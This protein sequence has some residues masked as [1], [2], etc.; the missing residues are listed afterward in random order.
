M[1]ILR[2]MRLLPVVVALAV[3]SISLSPKP[4]QAADFTERFQLPEVLSPADEDRYRR[5]FLLQK[6]GA[7]HKA[8][9]IIAQLEDKLLLGHVMAQRYLHPRKYRSK[10]KEL[11]G[12]MAQYADHP[13]A[14]QIYKLAMRRRPKNWRRPAA[15][16][17][18]KKSVA[19]ESTAPVKSSLRVPGKRRS[20]AQ[21]RWV[22][23]KERQIRRSSRRG[24][25]LIIKK[26]LQSREVKRLFSQ[27]EY[28]R[29]SAQLGQGYFSAGRDEWALKWAGNAAKR[30]GKYVPE[31]HWTAGLA[32][33]RLKRPELA[34]YHFE[35]AAW[36]S[37]SSTWFHSGAAFWAARANLV[38]RTPEKVHEF[39][40]MAARHPRTFYG[41]LAR[42]LMGRPL[43]FEWE[44]PRLPGEVLH[45]LQE[46]PRGKR[47][48]ALLQLDRNQNAERELRNLARGADVEL[49]RSL[50]ALAAE[51]NMAS[52]SVRLDALLY[53]AGGGYD[54]AA[55]PVPM[56]SPIG[57]FKIDRALIYALVRQESRFNPKAKSW[58]GARGLMQLMPGTASFVAR[59][60]R[61]RWSKRSHLY[62][63]EENLRLGQKYIGMLLKDQKIQGNLFL[64]AAAWNGGPGNLNK[65]RRKTDDMNDPLFFIESLPSRE[66]RGFIE[67]VLSNFWIYRDRLGQPTPSL[68]AVAAGNWPTYMPLGQEAVEVAENLG[69]GK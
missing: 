11:K 46:R 31:G 57:G 19:L 67:H 41:L 26:L 14:G 42:R 29:A 28:D 5:L 34:K 13:Q 16:N 6:K 3:G 51:G 2:A 68:E 55:Y 17:I 45:S 7:W 37:E 59:D 64:M 23:S 61:Y 56:W 33:W 54:G 50:L 52:L 30:S 36:L 66:T 40:A 65:W 49:G 1:N 53:P 69:S 43:D 15:P 25:T 18:L 48:L 12:W 8:D 9:K 27:A 62:R 39:L 58:A 63:P 44:T 20:R 35:Q 60:R 10:Y 38:T 21:T 47:A 32:A 24:H 22:R 4:V